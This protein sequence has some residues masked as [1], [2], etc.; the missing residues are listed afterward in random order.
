MHP[1]HLGGPVIG[2][3]TLKSTWDKKEA[4]EYAVVAIDKV[5]RP[6]VIWYQTQLDARAY[7]EVVVLCY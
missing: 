6:T 5:K 1:E 7:N 2:A 4:C 3:Q